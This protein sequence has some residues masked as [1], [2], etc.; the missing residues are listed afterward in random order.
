MTAEFV[1]QETANKEANK[2]AKNNA[3]ILTIIKPLI[4]APCSKLQ[5]IFDRKERCLS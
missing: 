2:Q 4:E 3:V 5:G 1:A